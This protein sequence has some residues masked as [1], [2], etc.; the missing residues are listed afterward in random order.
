MGTDEIN[1]LASDLFYMA[2]HNPVIHPT[3]RHVAFI[4]RNN[5]DEPIRDGQFTGQ[6]GTRIFL[7][8]PL[9]IGASTI[10]PGSTRD[11]MAGTDSNQEDSIRGPIWLQMGTT[12]Q[13]NIDFGNLSFERKKSARYT[14]TTKI[15]T[16]YNRTLPT[17]RVRNLR[18]GLVS[19]STQS[20]A[21]P[22]LVCSIAAFKGMTFVRK[23]LG[24]EIAR[25]S[26]VSL[27]GSRIPLLSTGR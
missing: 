26:F 12:A 2:P 10:R 7:K 23:A 5:T 25:R 1:N 20:S 19:P 24:L 11:W 18:S 15:D 13:I 21:F 9:P 4:L 3:F 8:R 22:S 16:E 27:S 14:Q 6:V 17:T